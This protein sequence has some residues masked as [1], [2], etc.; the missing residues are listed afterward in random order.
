MPLIRKSFVALLL[1]VG[2][3][4]V[5]AAE[6]AVDDPYRYLEDPADP[7]TQAFFREQGESAREALERIPGRKAMLERIHALSEGTTLV[8]ALALGGPRIFYLKLAPGAAGAVL[9]VREGIAGAE[10]VLLDPQVL[11]DGGAGASIDWFAPSPDGRHVAFG[12]SS[13]GSEDSVLRVLAVDGARVLPVAIDRARFNSALAWHPEGRAFYYSRTPERGPGAQRYANMRIYR[14]LLGRASDRDEIVFASGVGGARDVPELVF[15]SLRVP[16]ESRYAY[17]LARHGT[18]REIAVH[19]AEQRDLEL[20]RPRWRKLAG[21]GD[22]VLD[23][24]AFRNEI[25]LLSKRGAPRHRILRLRADAAGIQAARV[26]VAQGDTVIESMALARDALYL[27]TMVGGVDRLERVPFGL[28][29]AKAPEYVRTPFDNAI[30]Q[31]L[32]HPRADGAILRLQGWIDP[33]AVVQI[34]KR[35]DLKRTAIQPP[36]AVSF[37]DMDEVRLYAASHDGVKVPVT[38]VYAKATRL[39]GDNPTLLMGYGAYGTVMSPTFEPAQLAW[40]ERG[41]VVAIAHVRGGGEFGE[42]WR[43]GGRGGTKLNTVLDFIAV[44]R[45]LESYGFTSPR[46]LAIEGIGAGGIAVGGALVR[47]PEIFAAVVARAPLADMVRAEHSALGATS[48][49]EFGSAAT[50]PGLESLRAIS[51]YHQVKEGTSYPAVLLAVGMNDARVD[52][53]HAGKMAA[54]LQSASR[55]GKP[56]LLRVDAAAGH[57]PGALRA[58]REQEWADIY[59]FLLWQMGEPAFQPPAPPAP[60]VPL[61]PA[62]PAAIEP[63]SS[64]PVVPA[65]APAGGDPRN[66]EPDRP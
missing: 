51:S 5:R 48:I 8:T 60:V 4:A 63:P 12:I 10:R 29:G 46:R 14:H 22:G 39:N 57:G 2:T 17:A 23:V 25:F 44:A 26:L 16:L 18:R 50:A 21:E 49:P 58:Q 1:A 38:L 37:A 7:R 24:E 62:A 19:V 3:F 9:C 53:W 64:A 11:A 30:S 42:P 45:F 43:E 54:R 20:G 28:L 31:L 56:V 59:T 41:G 47:A 40:L 35:G 61:T 6:P 65:P 66:P 52:P 55:S 36:V 27:R 32:A 33:P 13:A 15:A 34:D